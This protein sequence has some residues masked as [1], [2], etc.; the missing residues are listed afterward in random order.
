MGN[1]LLTELSLINLINL[2]YLRERE[3]IFEEYTH[4]KT[5]EHKWLNLLAISIEVKLPIAWRPEK[6]QN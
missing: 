2:C 6:H 4:K 1:Y 3:R 5:N